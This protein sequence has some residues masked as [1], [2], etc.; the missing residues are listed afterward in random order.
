M[1]R[2]NSAGL[3]GK[4][5]T[6]FEL[7]NENLDRTFRVFAKEGKLYQSESKSAGGQL[8]FDATHPLDYAIGSGNHGFTFLTHRGAHL[9]Q[10]PLSFYSR[11]GTW[12]LSPGYEQNDY[13]FN[14]PIQA[15]CIVCHS[16]RPQPMP[17]GSG[18]FRGPPF[19]ELAI[20]CENC[21]GPGSSHVK[22]QTR[23]SIV[24]PGRLPPRLA[25]NICMQCHQDGNAR[26]L[27]PGKTFGDFRPGNWLGDTLAIFKIR[28]DARDKDLLEHHAAMQQ[29]QCFTASAGK[30]GCMTC[31][32]PHVRVEPSQ[33]IATY[34]ERCFT[35]HTDRSCRLPVEARAPLN[36]CTGCHMPKRDAAMISHTALTNHRILIGGAAKTATTGSGETELDWVNAPPGSA[37]AASPLTMLKAYAELRENQPAF[38]L[39]YFALLEDLQRTMPSDAFVQGSYGRKLLYDAPSEAADLAAL[40]HLEKAVKLGDRSAIVQQDLAEALVRLNRPDESIGH[41]RAALELQPYNPLLHKT[42]ALRLITRK[43]YSMAL[44]EMRRYVEL[45]PEDDFM[46]GLL[47]KASGAR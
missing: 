37:R 3:L 22:Q 39:R 33:A 24:N 45:F 18:L 16:G 17:E 23:A 43:K 41:L 20:G 10:A 42:L 34:R 6:Q 5:G 40:D 19:T 9:F 32:D 29:S 27:Q 13:G 35:C 31:H 38:R 26:V 46:R 12:D 8:V 28:T 47:E 4:I 21:H 36:D 11:T 25:E 44:E 2:A 30:L 14:R 15:A 1:A 7:R